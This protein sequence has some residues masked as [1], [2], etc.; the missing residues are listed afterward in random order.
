[1]EMDTNPN[2]VVTPTLFTYRLR[3]DHAAIR[4]SWL[5]Q[6]G[7]THS[8]ELNPQGRVTHA[9]APVPPALQ[10]AARDCLADAGEHS[11]PC[12]EFAGYESADEMFRQ[13]AARCLCCG[14]VQPSE[15]WLSSAGECGVCFSAT[16]A[17]ADDLVTVEVTDGPRVDPQWLAQHVAACLAPGGS[18]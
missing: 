7:A 1:M 15:D 13:I 10:L 3:D 2:P 16:M 17:V 11:V 5:A 12:T 9:S 4:I 8:A 18:F 14:K 6:T